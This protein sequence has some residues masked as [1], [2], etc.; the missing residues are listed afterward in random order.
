MRVYLDV[1]CLNRPF[2]DLSQK[3]VYAEAEAVDVF[4]TT[5]GASINPVT[6]ITITGQSPHSVYKRYLVRL[7]SCYKSSAL[8]YTTYCFAFLREGQQQI[9][10]R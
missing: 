1:C 2:D 7:P 10:H 5:E 3:R 6:Y 9:V 4:L 8:L